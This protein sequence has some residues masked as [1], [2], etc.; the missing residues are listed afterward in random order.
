M[1]DK[2]LETR[3]IG[4]ETRYLRR[5]MRDERQGT[6]DE[7]KELGDRRWRHEIGIGDM[8]QET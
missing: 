4:H 1:R 7:R 8:R 6:R 5:E 3:N 2:R